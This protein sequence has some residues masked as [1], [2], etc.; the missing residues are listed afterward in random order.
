MQL[1]LQVEKNSVNT[2]P[3]PLMLAAQE[4]TFL[5]M[6]LLC[7]TSPTL[8]LVTLGPTAVAWQLPGRATGT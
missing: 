7:Y 2:I 3:R 6:P 8:I 1:V 5:A 4:E